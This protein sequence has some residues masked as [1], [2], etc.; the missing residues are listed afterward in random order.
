[1]IRLEDFV[2]ENERSTYSNKERKEEL[3]KWLKGKNYPYYVNTLNK[4]LEDPKA[5]TLLVDGFGGDLGDTKFTFRVKLI[6]PSALRPT[7]N[8]IDVDKSIKHP[9][10]KPEN[11]KN[12]FSPEIVIANMPIVTFRGNY[13][14]D[15]HHRWSEGAMINPEGKMVCFDYDADI[16]PIQMLKAV[17]GNI[18][19]ALAERDKDPEIP[20]GKT[21]GPNL[22]SK[23]WNKEKIEEYVKDN[24][25]Q[26]C[27]DIYKKKT[28]SENVIED[29][30]TN[31]LNV[32]HNN[33]PEDNAPTRGEMPQTD[34]AGQEKGNKPSSYPDKKGSAL[35][36]MK[37]EPFDKNAI[38]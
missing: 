17:Q 13:V 10:T 21:N 1:M 12:D 35:N 36:R 3:E 19:A 23:E 5:K 22:Y 8:E 16:S 11:M 30:V 2:L 15:G 20:S 4:M 28:K 33:Y 38:K 32:K 31:I 7:Q 6:K 9:L 34:K 18:A 25:G 14:I 37:E 29:L 24:L 27:A 26:E